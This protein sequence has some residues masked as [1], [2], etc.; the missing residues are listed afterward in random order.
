MTVGHL[1]SPPSPQLID[2]L[3]TAFVGSNSPFI[4]GAE[5]KSVEN[6]MSRKDQCHTQINLE[7][8]TMIKVDSLN[9]K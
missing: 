4:N 8:G 5:T 1:Q 2:N 3:C 6:N 9:N 7:F